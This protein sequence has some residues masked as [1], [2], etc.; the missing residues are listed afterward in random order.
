MKRFKKFKIWLALAA[1]LA[2]AAAVFLCTRGTVTILMY[3]HIVPD[4]EETNSL[5]VTESKFRQD[6]EYLQQNGYVTLLP[7]ELELIL[8]GRRA[9]PERAVV[10]SFDDGYQSNYTIAYPILQ[11]TGCKAVVSLITTNIREA[12][13]ENAFMLCWP[14]VEEMSASGVVVFGS[15]TDNLHNPD[16]GGALRTAPG[17]ANGVERLQGEAR[18]SYF[19]RVG[20]DLKRSCDLIQAHTGKPV[21]WF[22]YPYGAGDRWCEAVLDELGVTISVSTNPGLARAR[23]GLRSLPRYGVQEDTDLSEL[24]PPIADES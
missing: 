4:G 1:V 7:D 11:E 6:M 13:G 17:A 24:L 10:V 18:E 14:E 22:A 16:V 5:T 12:P 15:H 23:N 8:R 9:C 3:H 21:E 2:V 19:E 20:N